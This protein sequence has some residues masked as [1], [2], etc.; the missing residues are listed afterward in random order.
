MNVR[1]HF[2][3]GLYSRYCILYRN[4]GG[5]KS[6]K[7]CRQILFGGCCRWCWCILV[8]S[9]LS[10]GVESCCCFAFLLVIALVYNHMFDVRHFISRLNASVILWLAAEVLW[11]IKQRKWI[12]LLWKRKI[13]RSKRSLTKRLNMGSF[14]GHALP[15]LYFLVLGCWGS[16]NC[17][18]NFS[19]YRSGREV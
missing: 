4:W 7:S 3:A 2:V 13:C 19:R 6:G 12:D 9:A 1:W 5:S 14:W 18:K 17:S 11:E 10:V 16:F 15:G 8:P